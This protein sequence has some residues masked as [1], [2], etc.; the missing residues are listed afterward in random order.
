MCGG[1]LALV[2]LIRTL[3]SYSSQ[4][5]V[6]SI[7]RNKPKDCKGLAADLSI[8]TQKNLPARARPLKSF[9]SK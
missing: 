3:H 2:R 1:A 4:L 6:N 9:A 5:G 7:L 8:Y